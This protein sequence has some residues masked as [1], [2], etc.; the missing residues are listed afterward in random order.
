VHTCA[1][2]DAVGLAARRAVFELV[3]VELTCYS[4]PMKLLE[5]VKIAGK[6]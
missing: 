4:H 5:D 3:V 6:V 2:A 1:K